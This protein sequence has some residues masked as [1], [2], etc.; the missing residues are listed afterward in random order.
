MQLMKDGHTIH[1]LDD[2]HR[3]APPK[4][5]YQ[6][7]PGRSAYELA[8]ECCGSG[9]PR[10]PPVIL[11]L[12]DSQPA[13]ANL[14]VAS[15][16]PEHR[17]SFDTHSGEPRNADLAF[18][19]ETSTGKVAVTV[20]AKA[21]EPFGDTV[22]QVVDVA[23]DRL[24]AKPE[25]R[26]LKRVADLVQSLIVKRGEATPSVSALRYQL[27]TAVAGSLALARVE[28]ASVAVLIAHE[29]ITDRTRDERHRR[30]AADLQRFLQRLGEGLAEPLESGRLHGPYRV[31]GRPLLARAVPLFVG[32]VSSNRR[33]FGG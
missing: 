20:E 1:S 21:D 32:K 3:F 22:E 29:F 19:G 16:F 4:R 18:V 8:R 30:N 6:W 5:D 12:L 26:G 33:A 24:I 15:A 27:L 31:P 9:V 23:L 11:R 2:W 13:T 7:V 10:V 14:Q 28:G 17:I 25:S